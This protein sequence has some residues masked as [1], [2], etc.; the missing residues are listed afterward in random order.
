[1]DKESL[2]KLLENDYTKEDV[3]K[4]LKGLEEKRNV[5]LRVNTIKSSIEEIKQILTQEEVLF[6]T[7]FWYKD[8]FI[9]LNKDEKFFLNLDIY[10]E[11]KIYLQSLSSMLPVLILEPKACENI[12]DMTAAPGSKTTQMASLTNNQ[13]NITAIEKNKIRCERL[14]YN[15]DKLGAK[16]VSVLNEDARYINES[17]S[18]DKILLDAPCSGTGTLYIKNRMIIE[19]FDNE[20]LKRV[21]SVQEALL[22]KALKILKP[23]Q[24]MI[25]S[26]CSILKRENEDMIM[27]VIKDFKVEVVP[28]DETQFKAVPRLPSKIKGAMVVRPDKYYEGFF[29]IHLKKLG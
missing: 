24:D 1:M 16:R 2:K 23:G 13:A 25:Y 11:G 6:E 19:E 18:F 14:K 12:L 4:I 7:V 3:L 22:R 10:K 27:Q 29:L 21:L 8:A 9:I 28:I 17:F 20:L 26:T 15:L 5:S